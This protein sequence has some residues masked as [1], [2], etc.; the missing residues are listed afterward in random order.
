V[1]LA[2]CV[3]FPRAFC[4]YVCPL[5]TLL[6]GFDWLIGKRVA[7]LRLSR[8]GW[9]RNAKYLVLTAVLAAAA[10]G[11]L[12][13]GFVAAIPVLTR[14]MLFAVAPVQMGLLK[15]WYL[16]PPMNVGHVVSLIL[17]G[18]ILSLS[19]LGRRFWCSYVC[20]TGAVFS[21]FNVF[22]LTQRRVT[23]ACIGCGKC[24]KACS[25]A[26]IEPDF[27]TRALNCTFC[28]SCGGVC[29][30]GAIEF[31][32]RRWS[33]EATREAKSDR[34]GA[35][36]SRRSVLAG[37]GGAA[38]TGLGTSLIVDESLEAADH[39]AVVRPPG[40][41][42]ESDFL[43]LCVRCGACIKVCPNNVLQPAGF[44]YGFDGLWTPKVV[45]DWSGC[46]PSCNNCGQVCPTGAIRALVVEEKAAARMGL[47][48]VNVAT[49]LPHAGR[50]ACQLCVDECRAA[51]YDAIEFIRV[52]GRLDEHGQPVEGSGYLAP[53]VRADRCVGCGLCQM[54]CHGI[55][56]K[57]KKLLVR[58]AIQVRAGEGNEDRIRDGSY[59]A[60]RR[61]RAAQ[62][63][64]EMDGQKGPG[65]TNDYLPDFLK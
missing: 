30:V 15:G 48:E 31:I 17:V 39:T 19:L 33:S 58:S 14:A 45:A 41:V 60:L 47:A 10:G 64:E 6:D 20:P 4:G 44:E 65:S 25:F 35:V 12:L 22:R 38:V 26:A 36:V 53:V 51:G 21:V 9:W 55:N 1:I 46:E 62:R 8:E 50:Q 59:V 27:S 61:Q 18:T 3:V 13:S 29:P 2:V 32:P 37:L 43:R 40:S 54:R 5:G 57:S 49:C 16:V 7:S 11:V 24:V 23:G 56:V 52:G 28:Q 42:P 34:Q 63:R